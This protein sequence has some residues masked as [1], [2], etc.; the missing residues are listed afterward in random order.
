MSSTVKQVCGAG[1]KISHSNSYLS[2]ISNFRLSKISDSDSRK[3]RKPKHHL[4]TLYCVPPLCRQ[5][6][7]RVNQ[8]HVSSQVKQALWKLRDWEKARI[9]TV[10]Y[11]CQMHLYCSSLVLHTWLNGPLYLAELKCFIC[12]QLNGKMNH[13]RSICFRKYV[14]IDEAQL[15]EAWPIPKLV[16]VRCVFWL[17]HRPHRTSYFNA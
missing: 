4:L 6:F 12:K 16:W 3:L 17:K 1:G 7:H 2:K 10:Y 5:A 8:M 13:V 15:Y 9:V 11:S 14:S